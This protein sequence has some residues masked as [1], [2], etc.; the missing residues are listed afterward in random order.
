MTPD[1]DRDSGRLGFFNSIATGSGH[2]RTVSRLGTL[3]VW[4]LASILIA[5]LLTRV[6]LSSVVAAARAGPA[7]SLFFVTAV[8][9]LASFLAD[10]WAT[11]VGLRSIRV[12]RPLRE[13]GY[14]RASSHLVGL[15][16]FT[17][18]QGTIGIYLAHTGS[19]VLEASLATFHVIAISVAT[20]GLLGA[21][22]V[23][24]GFLAGWPVWLLATPLTLI[25]LISCLIT[26]GPRR[27]RDRLSITWRLRASPL[28]FGAAVGARSLNFV[29]FIAL[30]WLALRTWGFELSLWQ[31][32]PIV[33]A[34]MLV[35]ALPLTPYGIGTVQ[36]GQVLLL[37]PY[38]SGA[39]A[40]EREA[41]VLAFGLLHQ[42]TS[43]AVQAS[44]G[45]I[46]MIG[47]RRQFRVVGTTDGH[48]L[49]RPSR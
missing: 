44:I 2:R 17:L 7:M 21:I 42:V 3:S 37:T 48:K 47:W 36:F 31:A 41:F 26:F 45:L 35:A 49:P 20:L 5:W 15:L 23:S 40:S 46:G 18:G 13:L 10:L 27:L 29:A 19:S 16:N 22:V 38:A 43:I 33:L 4:L 34:L 14:V 30:Y 12:T 25:L 1:R 8:Q 11:W 24:L 39:V 6:Q 32:F 28:E 9:I